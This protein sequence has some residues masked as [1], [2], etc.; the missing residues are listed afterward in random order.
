MPSGSGPQARVEQRAGY[1]PRSL[2]GGEAS[3]GA[4]AGKRVLELVS[5]VAPMFNEAGTAQTFYE[6]VRATLEGL[7]WELV[8]VDDGS[9]DGT[10]EVLARLAQEDSRVRVLRLS[11]NFGH[12]AALT[13]GL[14]H[15]SGDAVVTTDADLQDPPEFI[16]RLLEEWR[17]GADVVHAIR[18]ERPGEQWWRLALIRAFHR[19]FSR[20]TGNPSNSGDF[21]LMDRAALTALSAMP[22][23]N[24]FIRGMSAWI[25][26]RQTQVPYDRAARFAGETKYPLRSLLKLAAD[27]I[28]AFSYVPLRVAAVIGLL[29][30]M[31]ALIAIPVVVA[32]KIAGEYIPGIASITIVMLLLGGIQL[33]T[34]GVIGEYLAR[35]YDEVKRRPIYLVRE[36][37]N[38]AEPASPERRGFDDVSRPAVGARPRV[39]DRDAHGPGRLE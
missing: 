29:V 23:R 31:L 16:A 32:L 27:G 17:R 21:L 38:L 7:P 18:R 20:F 6:R 39:A 19:F 28:V 12:Q 24:R 10:G 30:S 14:D 25:G 22:E 4:A 1:H 5:V 36:R 37:H 13:A 8:L 3:D 35:A 2:A 11:R 9:T 34:L 26:F 33:L 15:A